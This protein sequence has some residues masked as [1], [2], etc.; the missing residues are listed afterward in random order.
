MLC[1]VNTVS[2]ESFYNLVYDITVGLAFLGLL[3][4]LLYLAYSIKGKT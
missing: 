2:P 1:W 3:L 4:S